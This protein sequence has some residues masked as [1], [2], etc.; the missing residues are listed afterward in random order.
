MPDGQDGN[1]TALG[2]LNPPG[3]GMNQSIPH[4]TINASDVQGQTLD[5][6][7]TLAN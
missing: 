7:D 3:I 5:P 4:Q 2:T 1:S 6:M